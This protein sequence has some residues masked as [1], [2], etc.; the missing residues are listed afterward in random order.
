MRV[1]DRPATHRALRPA[2]APA[3]QFPRRRSI[4]RTARQSGL[5]ARLFPGQTEPFPLSRPRDFTPSCQISERLY[6]AESPAPRSRR[7][8][9][10]HDCNSSASSLPPPDER[11]A[12]CLRRHARLPPAAH[13]ST[14][15]IKSS[16]KNL[17]SPDHSAC[18]VSGIPGKSLSTRHLSPLAEL[19]WRKRGG[20]LETGSP[21]SVPPTQPASAET[22]SSKS[23]YRDAFPA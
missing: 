2:G 13:S 1:K 12:A 17:G 20:M 7:G 15:T 10:F 11:R 5:S 3:T 22:Q 4:T 19:Q 16:E 8:D 6:R 21:H 9:A 23:R 14:A 18:G